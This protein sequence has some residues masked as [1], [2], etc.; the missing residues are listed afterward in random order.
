MVHGGLNVLKLK[1]PVITPLVFFVAAL[2]LLP[3]DLWAADSIRTQIRVIHASTGQTHLDPGLRDVGPE[4]TSVF[5]YSS[6]RLINQRT[7][8]LLPGKQG[9]VV[10]PG[11]R[12]LEVVPL[13]LKGR[14]IKY[15]VEIFKQGR[16]VF[17][18]EILLRNRSS[19]TIGGPEFEKGYLLFNIFGE[20]N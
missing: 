16:S 12:V 20:I 14:R 18:T 17:T 6:Y 1:F 11:A 3:W 13:G 15:K 4:L 10:L 9:R 7:M 5:K 8:N 19:I 2:F